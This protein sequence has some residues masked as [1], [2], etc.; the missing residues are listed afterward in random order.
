MEPENLRGMNMTR[1]R[2]PRRGESS[3]A[4][5][6]LSRAHWVV[7]LGTKAFRRAASYQSRS[8]IQ[9][10]L[11]GQKLDRSLAPEERLKSL[12]QK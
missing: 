11:T 10:H 4:Q 2:G 12:H 5:Q 7:A 8:F 6:T 1:E 9:G 3:G